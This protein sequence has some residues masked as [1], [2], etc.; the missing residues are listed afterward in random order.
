MFMENE[1]LMES[2]TTPYKINAMEILKNALQSSHAA[3]IVETADGSLVASWFCGTW[4][5]ELDCAVVYRKKAPG[6]KGWGEVKVLHKTPGR[7]EGNSC[8]LVD[9]TGKL[10]AF[11]NT[12]TKGWTLNWIRYKISSDNGDTW[13]EPRWFR[14]IYG[15]LIR[16]R[17]IILKNGEYLIPTYSEVAGYRSFVNISSDGGQTWKKHGRVGPH[18]LQP[19]VVQL[20]DESLLMYCRTDTLKRIYQSRST[21]NGRHWSKIEPTRFK[22]PNAGISLLAL[23]SGN[24]MV[25][26]NESETERCPLNV[27]L[28]EDEGKTWPYVKSLET[29]SNYALSLSGTASRKSGE[30]SYPYSIEAKDSTIHLVHTVGRRQIKHWHFD[31]EWIKTK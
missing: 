19:N 24:L 28:S 14:K 16:D 1:I 25:S 29:D 23:K 5:K 15:W 10:W 11:F 17:P 3:A 22:N 31:E 26:W 27:A 7:F 12:A 6:A 18:C 13:S 21:D 4:E 20:R 8:Y 9:K 2:T 30:F